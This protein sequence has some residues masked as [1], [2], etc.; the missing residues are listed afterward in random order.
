MRSKLEFLLSEVRASLLSSRLGDAERLGG[1]RDLS[2][3]L[4]RA[5]DLLLEYLRL[6]RLSS[7][8][9]EA[10]R[11]SSRLGDPLRSSR[12]LSLRSSRLGDGDLRL[13]E[14]D[15]RLGE[16]DLRLGEGDLRLGEGDLR[17]GDERRSSRRSSRSLPP[18]G[19]EFEPIN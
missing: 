6:S 9:G 14:G 15:L 4:S 18:L 7:R 5:G 1:V 16:G 12:L 17:L 3:L 8:L 2:L 10:L 19:L 11:L 13:G